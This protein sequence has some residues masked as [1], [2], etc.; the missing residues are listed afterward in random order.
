MNIREDQSTRINNKQCRAFIVKDD[1][2]LMMFRRKNGAE[3][4][5]FPGGHMQIG[6]STE[7][8]VI[9]EVEEETTI[10][11]K[12]IKSAFEFVDY[13]NEVIE[14]DYYF[15]CKWVSG[16]PE[17]SGE[18]SRRSTV[19]NYYEPKWVK[20]SE[21]NSIKILPIRAKEWLFEYL[22]LDKTKVE[23]GLKQIV[24]VSAIIIENGKVLLQKRIDSQDTH[25]DKWTTPSGKLE[26]NEHPDDA[27]IREVK[28]E[29]N[30]DVEIVSFVPRVDSFPNIKNKY[31]IVYLSYLCRIKNGTPINNDKEEISEI[32]WFDL[33]ELDKIDLIRG[34]LPSIRKCIDIGLI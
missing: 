14:Y 29:L 19:D 34:T 32:K 10:K 25:N 27:I 22:G 16:E 5:V 4:Y 2:I 15:L 17:L 33:I 11:C 7:Q 9:R 12:I 23:T 31:H 18:E 6:E 30:I 24:L 21:L 13:K 26:L 20:V 28:E 3:Y 1:K 8:T